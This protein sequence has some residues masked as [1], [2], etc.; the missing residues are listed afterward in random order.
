MFKLTFKSRQ[1][2]CVVFNKSGRALQAEGL[3]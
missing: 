1:S 2:K 3:T